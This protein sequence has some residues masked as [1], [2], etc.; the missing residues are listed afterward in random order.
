MQDDCTIVGRIMIHRCAGLASTYQALG[1][2]SRDGILCDSME[3][4]VLLPL[5]P[6]RLLHSRGPMKPETWSSHDGPYR[7]LAVDQGVAY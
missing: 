1:R 5:P 7:A 3:W 2:G 4:A 6:T